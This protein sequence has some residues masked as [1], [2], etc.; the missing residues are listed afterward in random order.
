MGMYHYTV[1]EYFWSSNF[2]H[3]R[4]QLWNKTYWKLTQRQR[5]CWRLW[6]VTFYR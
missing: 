6:Y 4:Y 2:Y 3:Y 1:A 5:R